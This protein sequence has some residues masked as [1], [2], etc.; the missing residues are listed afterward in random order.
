MAKIKTVQDLL[1]LNN[2]NPETGEKNKTRCDNSALV[3][4][5][6]GYEFTTEEVLFAT[7]FLV[8]LLIN[9][10]QDVIED[11]VSKGDARSIYWSYDL[12]NLRT[13]YNILKKYAEYSE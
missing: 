7:T 1:R 8:K 4:L 9:D 10:H 2:V 11:L 12:A 13:V 5:L 6:D 3:K